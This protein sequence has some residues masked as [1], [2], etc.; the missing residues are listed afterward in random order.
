MYR[1]LKADKDSYVT[2]KIIN[3]T[4]P[5]TSASTD[6]NVGQ[7]GTIDLFKL[8]NATTVPS[9]TSGVELSRGLIHFDLNDKDPK[10]YQQIGYKIFQLMKQGD[11]FNGYREQMKRSQLLVNWEQVADKWLNEMA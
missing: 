7:A 3:S 2:N 10:C 6:A 9:G 5:T 1:I 4:R 8:Y 11:K